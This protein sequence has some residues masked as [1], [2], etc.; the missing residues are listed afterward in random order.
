MTLCYKKESDAMHTDIY[1]KLDA[2]TAKL[3]I[4]GYSSDN[5]CW[6][7]KNTDY[8][9]TLTYSTAAQCNTIITN[10]TVSIVS[11]LQFLFTIHI[12]KLDS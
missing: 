8:C 4:K 7:V 10:A 2:G 3:Y 9:I 5:T 12:E 11:F 1:T 6:F